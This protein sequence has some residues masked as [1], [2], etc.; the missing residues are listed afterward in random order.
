MATLFES[1][2]IHGLKMANRFVRSATWEGLAG[3]DGSVT[4]RLAGVMDRLAQGG[5][6]LII[7]GHAYVSPEGQAGR[8]QLGAYSDH[9]LAGLGDLVSAVHRSGGKVALQ[10]AHAGAAARPPA[11]WEP[12]GP[13]AGA[14]RSPDGARVMT[15]DDIAH[16][17]QAFAAAA[18][19]A[20]AA[21]FDA[22]Q[23]HAAHGYLLSQFLSPYF[24][25]RPDRYGGAIANRARL[26]I[27]VVQ[28]IRKTVGP[29]YPVFIKLN[30]ADFLDGGLTVDE[31]IETSLMLEKHGIDGIEMSGGTFLS[32]KNKPSRTGKRQPGEPE[33]YYEAA[34]KHYKE[35]VAV[36]LMLVGGIRTIDTAERLV[37]SRIADY[38][39]LCRPLIREAGLIARWKAG[40]RNPALCISDNG[41]F[42]PGFKGLGVFCTVEAKKRG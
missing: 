13:S 18:G 12:M 35:K 17:V 29:D 16:A 15:E 30:C 11:G 4:P 40:D 5:V 34:A 21:G 42:T 7:T 14:P 32:G 27:E 3:D 33:A 39:A 31:M 1:T 2:D 10:L 38:I 37:A 41:C 24:N 20:R 28:G 6:G 19:R 25:K 36:P 26:T 22:V 8:W 9:L 23:V